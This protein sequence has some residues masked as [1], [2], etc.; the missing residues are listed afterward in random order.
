M[1]RLYLSDC[2]DIWDGPYWVRLNCKFWR[3]FPYNKYSMLAV[4]LKL[5]KIFFRETTKLREFHVPE[6]HNLLWNPVK[7]AKKSSVAHV[8]GRRVSTKRRKTLPFVSADRYD[9][10]LMST[11]LG[12]DLQPSRKFFLAT[13]RPTLQ[14]KNWIFRVKRVQIQLWTTLN[15]KKY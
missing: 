2:Y 15:G 13:Q 10:K 1:N 11:Y 9:P 3:V 8:S 14:P 7:N 12:Y 4:G 6:H 5:K